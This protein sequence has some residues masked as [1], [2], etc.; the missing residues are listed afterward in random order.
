[1]YK[2]GL[3]L[4]T[5][6]TIAASFGLQNLYARALGGLLSDSLNKSMDFRGRLIAQWVCLFVEGILLVIFSRM[7]T[8]AS[9]IVMLVAFSIFVQ[10][11][12]GSTYAIVPYVNPAATGAVTGVVGAGGNM[13]AVCW[14]MVFL[15]SGMDAS[16]CFMTIGCIV[17]GVSMLSP[18]IMVKGPY[19]GIF[20]NPRQNEGYG[21]S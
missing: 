13:G 14:G 11:S 4:V 1:M 16:D 8:L 5:A 17:I 6:G 21:K 15:F 20:C 10:A 9:A 2:F 12:E 7:E 19:G 18:L 3:G